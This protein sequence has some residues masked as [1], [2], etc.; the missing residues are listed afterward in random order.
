VSLLLSCPFLVETLTRHDD[1]DDDNVDD[2]PSASGTLELEILE[3][4]W[5]IRISSLLN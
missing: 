5:H 2:D 4:A 3:M 1:D